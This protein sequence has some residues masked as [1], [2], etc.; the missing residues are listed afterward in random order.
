L[1]AADPDA[2]VRAIARHYVGGLWLHLG[3]QSQD[4][5]SGH[6]P[7]CWGTVSMQF[8]LAIVSVNGQHEDRATLLPQYNV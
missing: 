3:G 4:G 7:F 5:A 8:L 6:Q 1:D 2:P